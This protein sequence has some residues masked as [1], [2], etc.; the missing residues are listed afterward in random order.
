[1]NTMELAEEYNTKHNNKILYIGD[2]LEGEVI[3]RALDEGRELTRGDRDAL[4]ALMSSDVP[5]DAVI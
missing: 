1:M 2:V 4:E 5:E 3:K